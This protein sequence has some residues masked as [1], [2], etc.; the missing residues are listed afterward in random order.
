MRPSEKKSTTECIALFE[1]TLKGK[2]FSK[3]SIR[4]YRS[5]LQQFLEWLKPRRVDFDIP[6]QGD[7][8]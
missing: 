3:E 1:E 8:I 5:D 7:R 2:N 4:A 6:H